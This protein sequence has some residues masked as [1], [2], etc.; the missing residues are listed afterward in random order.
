M[1]SGRYHR[2][3]VAYYLFSSLEAVCFSERFVLAYQTA[4]FHTPAERSIRIEN[5]SRPFALVCL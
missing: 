4:L 2:F 1:Y 5:I 3:G